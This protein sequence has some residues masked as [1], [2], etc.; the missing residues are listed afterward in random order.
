MEFYNVI[1]TRRSIRSYKKEP[2]KEDALGRVLEAIRLSPSGSNRQPW[3]FIIVKDFEV[4][5]KLAKHCMN[6]LWQAEAPIMIVACGP[7]IGYN[8]GGWMGDKS[9][10]I[11]V[12]I[13]FTHLVL[14][15]RAE[16]LGTCWIGAFN[17]D[18]IKEVLNI[19]ENYNVV[20]ITALGYPKNHEFTETDRRKPL[21][22]VFSWD[23]F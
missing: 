13:A 23:K 17:N 16:G 11:D 3:K 12:A 5:S 20:A 10:A 6:Q 7:D 2:I 14:A 22:E 15:A 18:A 8:R 1:K 4:K 9:G 21:S 19:P